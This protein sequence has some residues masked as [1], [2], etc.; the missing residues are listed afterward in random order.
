VS[1]GM[2]WN[3]MEWEMNMV[4]VSCSERDHSISN[5]PS[6]A[7]SSS[8]GSGATS[9]SSAKVE[10]VCCDVVEATSLLSGEDSDD[11]SA[12]PLGPLIIW[13][14][15]SEPTFIFFVSSTSESTSF[16]DSSSS[17]ISGSCF[18]SPDE[19]GCTLNGVECGPIISP[20]CA[21]IDIGYLLSFKEE[22]ANG[23]LLGDVFG[24]AS[25]AGRSIL[26]C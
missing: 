5:N 18:L 9:F 22:G 8:L 19:N 15:V 7:S 24:N 2:E 14:I 26:A 12:G 23:C 3:G 6:S 10:A 17:M 25:N 21:G 16:L 20:R 13:K 4:D 1:N 11:L